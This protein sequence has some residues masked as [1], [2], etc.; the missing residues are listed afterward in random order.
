VRLFLC[1]F[2]R[3][4]VCS[5]VRVLDSF[6]LQ[7]IFCNFNK[8]FTTDRWVIRE[9]AAKTCEGDSDEP[10]TSAS[11]HLTSENVSATTSVTRTREE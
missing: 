2:Y 4:W 1:A 5:L 7:F 9:P 3:P 8:C 10:S 11:G 6:L